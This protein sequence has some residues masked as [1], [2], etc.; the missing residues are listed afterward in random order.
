MNLSKEAQKE[1]LELASSPAFRK[2]MD[3]VRSF[4]QASLLR[5]GQV[6]VDEYLEFVTQYNEFINHQRRPFKPILER[7]MKL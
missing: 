5:G 4:W 6:A 1:L 7:D 2:D 3:Q